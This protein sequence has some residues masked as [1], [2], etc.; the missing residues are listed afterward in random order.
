M[1]Y[2]Y[3]FFLIVAV[4]MFACKKEKVTYTPPQQD[5]PDT[6][7][8]QVPAVLLKDIVI[9]NLPS[10]Y[11][12]FEYDMAGKVS[13]ASF[14]SDFTRYDFVYNGNKLGEMRNNIIVNRDTLRYFYDGAGRAIA[15]NYTDITGT[16]YIKVSLTYNGQKLVK[17]ERERKLGSDFVVNKV[18][19]FSYY[20]DGNL[21]E[22][23]DHRP[24]VEGRQPESTSTDR[25]EQYDDKINV[26]A[27]GLIHNEFFDHLVFLPG[28]QL[29]KNNPRKETVSGD[30]TNYTVDYTYTYNDRNL[31]LHKAGD[32]IFTGG[33]NAGQRFQTNS[34]YSYY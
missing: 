3:L 28:V 27:F 30:G 2:R 11:Y 10:P 14:A 17:L 7:V 32:L 26:D 19:T 12:H 4:M 8:S 29:Q 16:L 24:A 21:K 25:F 6:T 15:V 31:P 1:R 9:P 18:M 20:A 22:I 5:P 34:F 23:I 13:F 33:P